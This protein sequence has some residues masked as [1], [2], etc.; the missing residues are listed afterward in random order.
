MK[1]EYPELIVNLIR[2]YI[3]LLSETIMYGLKGE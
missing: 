3:K 1:K 2:K